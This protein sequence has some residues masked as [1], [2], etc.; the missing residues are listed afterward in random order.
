VEAR[1]L[2]GTMRFIDSSTETNLFGFLDRHYDLLCSCGGDGGDSNGGYLPATKRHI[3][4]IL[5][6]LSS[7]P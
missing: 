4:L 1:K 2:E 6:C 7:P 3:E 5:G